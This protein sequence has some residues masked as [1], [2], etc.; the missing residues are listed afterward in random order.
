MRNERRSMS[1]NI[2]SDRSIRGTYLR[3]Y[4]MGGDIAV[5]G[6]VERTYC[7][8]KTIKLK[9]PPDFTADLASSSRTR[10]GRGRERGRINSDRD[11]SLAYVCPV[12]PAHSQ[13][14]H[15]DEDRRQRIIVLTWK[16]MSES[17]GLLLYYGSKLGWLSA[18]AA[19]PELWKVAGRQTYKDGS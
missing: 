16:R 14:D 6:S 10:E 12:F 1:P 11:P 4:N 17:V 18:A 15:G 9:F 19:A 7:C 5:P 8:T 2:S 13:R 3:I